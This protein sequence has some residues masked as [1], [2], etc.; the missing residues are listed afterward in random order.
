MFLCKS[1]GANTGGKT[2]FSFTHSRLEKRER[3][4]AGQE[5]GG[6]TRLSPRTTE[7]VTQGLREPRTCCAIPPHGL[8]QRPPVPP[9]AECP[10]LQGD[11]RAGSHQLPCRPPLITEAGQLSG[12][13]VSQWPSSLTTGLGT[14]CGR[15]PEAPAAE[16]TPGRR[17]NFWEV[18]G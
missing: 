7:T 3:A 18:T 10:D 16:D 8:A 13:P 6:G 11:A 1:G 9:T 5:R 14:P 4:K 15:E 2:G 17:S 12:T